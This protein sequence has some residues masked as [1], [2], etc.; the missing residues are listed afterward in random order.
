MKFDWRNNR[1]FFAG[2]LYIVTGAVAMWIARDYPMGTALRMGP[3]YF[4]TVLGGITVAFGIA[5]LLMGVKNNEKIKGNW[6]IRA[7]IVLPLSMVIF[8]ILMEEAGFIPA[9]FVLVVI[10]ALSGREFKWREAIPLAIAL[11]V[12]CTLVFIY[13]LGL[14][15]PLIKGYWG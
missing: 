8:G 6:S 13:G 9:L 5:V 11:I 12:I 7:L 2:L 14:P 10:S 3:G 1:D 4:P 15:Y